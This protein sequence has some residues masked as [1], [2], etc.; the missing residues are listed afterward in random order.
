MNNQKKTRIKYPEVAAFLNEIIQSRRSKN[1]RYSLRAFARDLKISPARLSGLLNGYA[2][3]GK[4]VRDHIVG[5]LNL[6]AKQ[7][8]RFLYLVGKYLQERKDSRAPH[9]LDDNEL[10][11]LPDWRHF[12][13]LNIMEIADFQSDSSWISNRLGLTEAE[14]KDSLEK[15]LQAGLAV[16]EGGKLRPT[17]SNTSSSHDI[18][19]SALRHFHRQF[20]NIASKAMDEVPVDQRDITS[21]ILAGDSLNLGKVKLLAK[22]FRKEACSILE[23]GRRDELYNIS[24]QIVPV[25][26]K[27]GC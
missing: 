18:P 26:K 27:L 9:V 13:I 12:A 16:E 5:E 4:L 11:L 22:Q 2:L 10:Q 6:E 20:L 7:R 17:Y 25:T 15:L 24:I 1:P 8:E 23:N 3:P 19:S 14:V 21:L